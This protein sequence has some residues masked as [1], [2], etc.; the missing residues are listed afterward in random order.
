VPGPD[1]DRGLAG[2]AG[3]GLD[4]PTSGFTGGDALDLDGVAWDGPPAWLTAMDLA[5]TDDSPVEPER[6]PDRDSGPW[7]DLDPG[8]WPDLDAGPWPDDASGP[9]GDLRPWPGGDARVGWPVFGEV[10]PS[11]GL[12]SCLCKGLASVYVGM[13]SA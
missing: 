5:A 3:A 9:E 1:P 7:P 11:A 2:P 4:A 8:P 10:P 6:W 12:S 13:R